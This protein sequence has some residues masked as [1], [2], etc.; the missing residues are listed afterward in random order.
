MQQLLLDDEDIANKVDQILNNSNMPIKNSSGMNKQIMEL[1]TQ[2]EG[3]RNKIKTQYGTASPF[4]F[5]KNKTSKRISALNTTNTSPMNDTTSRNNTFNYNPTR[6]HRS[7]TE[8]KYP[9]KHD[10]QQLDA[11]A[12]DT[13]I[14]DQ[15]FRKDRRDKQTNPSARS[16][17]KEQNNG[18]EM[19][20]MSATG[21]E[22]Y[23]SQPT[24]TK[25]HKKQQAIFYGSL[26]PKKWRP[27]YDTTEIGDIL[28]MQKKPTRAY[29]NRQSPM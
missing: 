10:A 26:H 27:T 21:G 12:L 8:T 17:F 28:G 13:Q 18:L 4:D 5:A 25:S 15:E 2:V 11:G 6:S 24:Q 19:S 29:R 20:M 9:A 16:P 3:R 7:G 23:Y 1:A 14:N 22:N